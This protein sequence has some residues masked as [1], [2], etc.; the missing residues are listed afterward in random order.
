MRVVSLLATTITKKEPKF[1]CHLCNIEFVYFD[2]VCQC[3]LLLSRPQQGVAVIDHRP[4]HLPR[5][6]SFDATNTECQWADTWDGQK[7]VANRAKGSENAAKKKKN[8]NMSAI[9][10]LRSLSYKGEQLGRGKGQKNV[11]KFATY[12]ELSYLD[13]NYNDCFFMFHFVCFYVFTP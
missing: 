2:V 4:E 8:R 3:R 9:G 1:R 13:K 5:H 10:P 12:L 6:R 7:G 11:V